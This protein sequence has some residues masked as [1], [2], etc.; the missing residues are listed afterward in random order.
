MTNP[1]S[2]PPPLP[3]VK[4]KRSWRWLKIILGACAGIVLAINLLRI[5]DESPSLEVTVK[6]ALFSDD[7][8]AAEFINTDTKAIK[9]EGVRINDRED[10]KISPLLSPAPNNGHFPIELKVGDKLTLTSS[11]RIVRISVETDHG[12]DTYSFNGN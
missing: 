9:I 10:C 5:A 4:A 7:R 12:S 2:L 1:N 6:D 8:M 11:C 3:S